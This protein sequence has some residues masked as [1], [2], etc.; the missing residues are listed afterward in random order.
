MLTRSNLCIGLLTC[1]VGTHLY[2]GSMGS[3]P[4]FAGFSFGA[5]G[6]YVNANSTERS[7]V[8]LVSPFPSVTQY[9][10]EEELENSFSPVV[11]ASY[12]F[13]LENHWLMGVKA[14]YKYLSIRHS[15]LTWSGTFQDGT[16][17]QADIHKKR[18]QEIFLMLDGAYQ[19]F[20]NWLVY[21]GIGPSM[22]DLETELRGDVLTST[23]TTF[24]YVEKT[25][26]KTLWGVAGQI[27]FEYLLPK[28][29]TIDLSY[30]VVVTPTG[31]MPTIFFNTATQ[32]TY[33]TISQ[34]I[35]LLEQGLNVTVNKY[36]S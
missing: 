6:G 11:N 14:V 2:A 16:V 24:Q 1:C 20:P 22:T 13:N 29:F 36:F 21:S 3:S 12:F 32:G 8:T 31:Q 7:I 5:G 17:Q 33:S 25:D 30:N 19:L 26:K 27:G 9:F 23:S 4:G 34:R 28:R 10:R 35:Q 15:A 18:E